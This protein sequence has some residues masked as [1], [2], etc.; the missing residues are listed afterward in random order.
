[1][2]LPE[3]IE[4]F[5]GRLERYPMQ[6]HSIL[7]IHRGTVIAERYYKP[8]EEESLHRMYSISKSFTSL[9]VGALLDEGKIALSDPIADYFP[10]YLP[11][12]PS[13][14]ITEM[15]IEHLLKMETC[16]RQTTYKGRP[17]CNWVESF[18]TARPDHGPGT[19]FTYDTSSAH[20][21]GALVEKLSGQSLL[22]YLRGV[23]LDAI[24]FSREAYFLKDPDGVSCGGSGLMAKTSDLA[25]VALLL[26]QNGMWDGTQIYPAWY[27]KEATSLK[28]HTLAKGQTLEE[29]QGYG[30]QFWRIR[31]E[32]G[33]M[34]YGMGGQLM[35][36]CPDLDFICITTADCLGVQGGTQLICD[37]LFEC[38]LERA[39][40]LNGRPSLG[41]CGIRPLSERKTSGDLAL[42]SGL[43]EGKTYQAKNKDSFFQE[44]YVSVSEGNGEGIFGYR[45]LKGTGR[46]VFGLAELKEGA[47]PEYGQHYV[48]SAVW[49]RSDMLF[50]M[51]HLIGEEICSIRIQLVFRGD[52]V[53]VYMGNTGEFCFTEF[54]GYYTAYL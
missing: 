18:F 40:A 38:I 13:P 24:G 9:A 30:Y 6:M 14:W 51:I 39:D 12:H 52:V 17:E 10:E 28:T 50:V 53:T 33:Y 22:D 48:A 36:C 19:V 1:M 31:N 49:L 32:R 11:E 27:I 3:W 4:E 34:C 42:M 47:F 41:T 45:T 20:T 5:M 21:L 46:L 54:E 29:Q 43:F 35:I 15:T 8:F 7:L 23:C 37:S 26:M 25:K 16:H 2:I 44:F